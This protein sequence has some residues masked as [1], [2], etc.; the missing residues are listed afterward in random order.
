MQS[1]KSETNLQA[2]SDNLQIQKNIVG[3]YSK[4]AA[5]I[6]EVDGNKQKLNL[7]W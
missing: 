4:T 2:G 5:T 6:Y 3:M 7:A 1:F